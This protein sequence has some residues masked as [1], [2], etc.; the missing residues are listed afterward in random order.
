M[1]LTPSTTTSL[2]S[3]LPIGVREAIEVNLNKQN[4]F[5]Y[6]TVAQ[7]KSAMKFPVTPEIAGETPAE[8]DAYDISVVTSTGPTITPV[9]VGAGAIITKEMTQRGGEQA[10]ASI[11]RQ[12]GRSILA[13]K[14]IAVWALFDG[15]TTN[16][17]GTTNVDFTEANL[18]LALAKL[19]A[20]GAPEGDG[21][22]LAVTPHVMSDII[23][24]YKTSTSVV[25]AGIREEITNTGR[26]SRLFGTNVVEIADLTPGTGAGERDAADAKCG[27]FSKEAIGVVEAQ[28]IQMEIDW[29]NVTQ[30]WT[31][32]ATTY[33]GVGEIKDEWGCEYLCD[34]KD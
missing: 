19:R 18:L 12:L 3:F 4:L 1:A 10:I 29:S 25:A 13:Q 32:T 16:T 33:F 15:F 30:S 6:V 23:D 7:N 27:V 28:D 24:L 34:N 26:V 9:R 14:N 20:A 11:G 22:T 31:I 21:Y 2:A 5:N 8:G 17:V